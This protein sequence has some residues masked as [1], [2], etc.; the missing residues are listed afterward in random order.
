[1][2]GRPGIQL[3]RNGNNQH[4]SGDA[5]NPFYENYTSMS[6]LASAAQAQAPPPQQQ[7]VPAHHNHANS[8]FPDLDAHLGLYGDLENQVQSQGYHGYDES[9]GIAH[10]HMN[11]D[12]GNDSQELNE[13]YGQPIGNGL[14]A[15]LD[16]YQPLPEQQQNDAPGQLHNDGG[17]PI[18]IMQPGA[19]QVGPLE[20]SGHRVEQ[21]TD[22]SKVVQQELSRKPHPDRK[23]VEV[24]DDTPS[25]P[26][27]SSPRKE[28][29]PLA[30]NDAPP[31]QWT[32]FPSRPLAESSSTWSKE[33]SRPKSSIPSDIPIQEY[34]RQCIIA[35]Y[36][37]RMNPF[38][39]HASEHALLRKHLNYLQ[40]TTY[41]NIRN[42][43][44]RLWMRNPLL[45]V[46]K[47][48]A[49]GCAKDYRWF[50]VANV[51]FQ[52]LVRMG[53][54][55]FGC[56]EVP[57]SHITLTR[58]GSKTPKPRRKTVVVIGAGMAGLGCA[59]QL[60][61]LFAHHADHWET[62]GEDL[63]KV[64][65]VEGRGRIGGRVYSHPLKKQVSEHLPT[66]LRCTADMGAQIITGFDHGNPLNAIIRGQLALHYHSLKDHST[67]YDSD[68]T[69]VGP[70]QDQLV[71]N[72][73]NDILDRSSIYRHK[74][75]PSHTAE[76]AKELLEIGRD[77]TGEGGKTIGMV[78]DATAPIPAVG[79]GAQSTRNGSTE[80]VPAGMDK[81]T[82]KAFMTFGSSEKAPAITAATAMGWK[83]KESAGPPKSVNLDDMV[84]STQNPTLGAAM[85]EAVRQ[86]QNLVEL[87]AQDMRLLNWHFANLEYAN[88]ANVGDLSLGG[89]DQDIGNEF[90][91]EHAEIIGGYQQVPRGLWRRPTTLDVRTRKAVKRILYNPNPTPESSLSKIEC[92]DGEVIEADTIISTLPLGVLKDRSV[93]F[94]PA[95]P[96][97]K[98][99]SIERLGFGTLNKVIAVAFLYVARQEHD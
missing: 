70:E 77:P 33:E 30:G 58:V 25:A 15:F 50:G 71:E 45:S 74:A 16:G 4:G 38:A 26:P 24:A 57:S 28:K 87:S 23:H 93:Q 27:Q 32:H 5:S 31:K 10:G 8:A 22:D 29:S 88:A 83:I 55:N 65:L 75:Q 59:R 17:A 66:G 48:E 82:G 9:N 60:E 36:S 42:G 79:T 78:E 90:E 1:M 14:P 49:M 6:T 85:D 96:D 81:L 68:G 7:Y 62:N 37:S 63:P 35:A 11:G 2:S 73:F 47:E 91:G 41:L 52:W 67:L 92:T 84:K 95:L 76:G 64:F 97:W 20:A 53:Y 43:I 40:V 21:Q 94:E 34:A 99:A 19:H 86:Y 56:V 89:W 12:F 39:L 51:A 69:P 61:G 54:I 80:M 3:P 72:L 98:S 13:W 46:T 44:L 18:P